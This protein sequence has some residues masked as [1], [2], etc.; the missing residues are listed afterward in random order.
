[1]RLRVGNGLGFWVGKRGK[2]KGGI[3]WGEMR[4]V[5]WGLVWEM[6]EGLRVEKVEGFWVMKR[7]VL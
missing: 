4:R 7:R 1:M 2:A 6:G 3:R 5:K